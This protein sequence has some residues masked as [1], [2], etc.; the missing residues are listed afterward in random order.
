MIL[1][2]H[3]GSSWSASLDVR[4]LARVKQRG[5]GAI[6]CP[7]RQRRSI[8]QRRL[9]IDVQI[10][11]SYLEDRTTLAFAKPI[12]REFGG[13]TPRSLKSCVWLESNRRCYP[14]RA[15]LSQT[16]PATAQTSPLRREAGP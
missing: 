2:I 9:P 8:A 5:S 1:P 13:F 15:S 10:V 16:L 3:L 12:E 4:C 7:R 14:R 11:G 6:A